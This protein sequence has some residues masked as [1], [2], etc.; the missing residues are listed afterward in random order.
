MDSKNL[1]VL[2][3]I[4]K[5]KIFFLFILSVIPPIKASLSFKYPTALTLNNGNIFIIHS[6]GIDVCDSK[7]TTSIY[8]LRFNSEMNKRILSEVSIS[9]YSTGE[10][11]VFIIN[12]FYLFDGNGT[13][14]IQSQALSSL[15]G[16]YYTL[17][18]HKRVKSSG[19]NY[20]Y[21]IFGY[22][23]ISNDYTFIFY[24]YYCYI[25]TNDNSIQSIRISNYLNEGIKYNGLTCEIILYNN[26][27]HIMCIYELDDASNPFLLSFFSITEGSTITISALTDK[28]IYFP[29]FS[30]EYFQ[31]AIKSKNSKPFFCILNV[32]G[33]SFCFI[34]DLYDANVIATLY[35]DPN[36]QKK[37]VK[38]P[39]NIKTYYFPETGEYVFSCLTVDHGIQTTIYNKSMEQPNEIGNPSMRL[40]KEF[41]GCPGFNYSLIYSQ[42]YKKYYVISDIVCGSYKNFFPLI[43]EKIEEEEEEEEEEENIIDVIE[44]EKE[45][46][47][48]IKEEEK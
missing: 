32:D 48:Y 33:D 42:Y 39:Y 40:Q 13:K 29:L 45:I 47:K 4:P 36:N 12:I 24:L 25:N 27:D 30:F 44:E 16:E 3:L 31:S 5:I 18:A 41:P 21:F 7:Y 15:Y 22:I 28:N 43:E 9:K 35:Y 10:I 11:L 19:I 23:G 34:Y 1:L 2:P 20:Y 17:K 6:L 8:S 38:E 37:C 26:K 14:K 46:I